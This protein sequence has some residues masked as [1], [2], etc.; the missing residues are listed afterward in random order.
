MTKKATLKT[1]FILFLLCILFT[2]C[3]SKK[4][5][6]ETV[7][8]EAEAV[9]NAMFTAPNE[10]LYSIDSSTVIGENSE[11]T[12]DVSSADS[13]RILENWNDLLGKYFTKGRLEYFISTYAQTYLSEAAYNDT[14]ITVKKISLE[15]KTDSSETV[16]VTYLI[17][18]TENTEK[19]HFTYDQDGLIK[20]ISPVTD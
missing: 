3:S 1:C 19:I 15:S 17:N 14:S 8:P 13:E 5:S 18:K 4:T 2:G 12:S 10:E 9:I 7:S 16:L 11:A 6:D 20:D